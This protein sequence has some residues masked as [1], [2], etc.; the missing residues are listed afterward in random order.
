MMKILFG[1]MDVRMKL[2]QTQSFIWKPRS[3]AGSARRETE[4][5]LP[6]GRIS[7]DGRTSCARR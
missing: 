5:Q 4:R 1:Q 3:S 6:E 7:D 2:E